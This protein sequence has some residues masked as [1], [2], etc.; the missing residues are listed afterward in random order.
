[1]QGAP[2]ETSKQH[3]SSGMTPLIR[4]V[5]PLQETSNT[6]LPASS[7]SSQVMH[8]NAHFNNKFLEIIQSMFSDKNGMKPE[9]N[10]RKIAR[11]SSNACYFFYL[12]EFYDL[13]SCTMN[14]TT[15]FY[16]ISI[17]NPQP[18]LPPSNLTSLETLSCSKSV[19]QYLF[20]KE[21]CCV[22]F[23]DSACKCQ[24]LMLVSHCLTNFTQHDNFQVH[25]RCCKCHYLFPFNG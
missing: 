3:K 9:I 13:Y 20:C 19:S 14:I 11:K 21:V 24:H 10:N 16:S 6:I 15:Q 17:P 23:L 8:Q 18:I 5:S 22:L 4:P 2:P 12:H 1:M 7:S 25:P